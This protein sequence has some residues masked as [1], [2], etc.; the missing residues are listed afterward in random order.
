MNYSYISTLD[1][2]SESFTNSYK[3][4]YGKKDYFGLKVEGERET[5]AE[6]WNRLRRESQGGKASKDPPPG[7]TPEEAQ[8]DAAQ[9]LPTQINIFISKTIP[10]QYKVDGQGTE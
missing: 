4:N 7:I 9:K 10:D 5:P 2:F 1:P 6:E 8:I 3:S